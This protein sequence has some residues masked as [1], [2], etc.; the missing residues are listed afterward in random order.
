MNSYDL[1]ESAQKYSLLSK[2]PNTKVGAL[3]VDHNGTIL[4]SACNDYIS[5]LY[6]NQAIIIDSNKKYYSEHA[7]RHLIYSS[8]RH[9]VK[10]YHDKIMVITHMPCSDCARAIILV[11]IRKIIIGRGHLEPNFYEKWK[12]NLDASSEMLVN[13]KVD[14]EYV[15][16]SILT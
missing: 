12:S 3:L 5:P 6:E 13:N 15:K 10:Y 7:E 8:I 2:K 11:G 9:G 16:T 4:G 1:M 14:I